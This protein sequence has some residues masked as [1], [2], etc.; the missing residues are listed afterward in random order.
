MVRKPITQR[1]AELEERRR[2]LLTRLSKQA[3]ARDTRRKILIGALVL[4]RLENA[5]DPAFS[6]RLLEWLRSELPGFLTRE[7]DSRLFDDILISAQAQTNCD[8]EEER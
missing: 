6:T 7:G 4:D 2:V 5:R 3:R 1:I 8:R